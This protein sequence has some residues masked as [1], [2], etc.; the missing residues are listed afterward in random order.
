MIKKGSIHFWLKVIPYRVAK[1]ISTFIMKNLRRRK[2]VT[3]G[4]FQN[5]EII[6][7]ERFTP[8]NPYLVC[9]RDA[10]LLYLVRDHLKMGTDM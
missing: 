3:R 2:C 5:V 10:A 7:K 9:N 8:I 1:Y 6:V 4:I